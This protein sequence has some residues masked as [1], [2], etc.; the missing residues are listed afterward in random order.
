MN[1]VEIAK[2]SIGTIL[3]AAGAAGVNG[4]GEGTMGQAT[5][6]A[7]QSIKAATIAVGNA[8]P[9]AERAASDKR[10]YPEGRAENVADITRDMAAKVA[11]SISNA[12]AALTVANALVTINARPQ[13]S[14]DRTAAQQHL[15]SILSRTPRDKLG[16]KVTEIA[17]R[18]SDVAAVL[19]SE[20]GADLL[21]SYGI[22]AVSRKAFDAYAIRAAEHSSSAKRRQAFADKQ[23]LGR[24]QGSIDAVN[25][26]VLAAQKLL[27]QLHSQAGYDYYKSELERY[28][29]NSALRNGYAQ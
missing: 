7:C 1:D 16:S 2:Q 23:K 4:F 11:D 18:D 5:K 8:I 25:S 19:F 15:D 22:D 17:G 20:F 24:I 14:G 28:R 13:L 27:G 12:E 21:D 9:A 26:G 3:A 6:A 10:T 29:R